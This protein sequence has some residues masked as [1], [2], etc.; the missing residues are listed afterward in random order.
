LR[1][2]FFKNLGSYTRVTLKNFDVFSPAISMKKIFAFLGTSASAEEV[3]AWK[4]ETG[5][6]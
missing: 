5:L 1:A 4:A 2:L 3:E 6:K